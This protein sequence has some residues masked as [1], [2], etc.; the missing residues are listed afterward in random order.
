[1]ENLTNDE[2]FKSLSEADWD[3][4]EAIETKIGE[5]LRQGF[6]EEVGI[7]FVR[8]VMKIRAVMP[9][10]AVGGVFDT[11]LSVGLDY[12]GD[13]RT[14]ARLR[15]GQFT[16]ATNGIKRGR[17]TGGKRGSTLK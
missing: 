5:I 15:G 1:M 10:A 9:E 3:K 2:F 16:E 11:A 6:T 13:E 12:V 7:K 4:A 8:T 17:N 14:L